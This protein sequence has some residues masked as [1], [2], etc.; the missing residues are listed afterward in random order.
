MIL[1]EHTQE[2]FLG[3][4]KVGNSFGI[5]IILILYEDGLL[6]FLS[7]RLFKG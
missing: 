6:F 2:Q 4:S 3:E 7:L 1:S 5:E